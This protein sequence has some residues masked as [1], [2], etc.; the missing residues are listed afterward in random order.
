MDLAE[1][2]EVFRISV[3]SYLQLFVA[4]VI[5]C[6]LGAVVYSPGD[7]NTAAYIYLLFAALFAANAVGDVFKNFV[8]TREGFEL[9]NVCKSHLAFIWAEV[10]RIRPVKIVT[11]YRYGGIP[12]CCKRKTDVAR[13]D[14]VQEIPKDRRPQK[15]TKLDRANT[16][17]CTIQ[18]F[19]LGG[20]TLEDFCARLNALRTGGGGVAAVA[21]AT[22]SPEE[23]SSF[24]VSFSEGAVVRNTSDSTA[25]SSQ[26]VGTLPASAVITAIATVTL[27]SGASRVQFEL[28]G[29]EGWVSDKSSDSTRL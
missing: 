2:R 20:M 15:M 14:L 12:L 10:A 1:G 21:V 11:T 25:S 23:W 29:L 5:C 24:T 13:I 8:I 4:A 7:D 26:I 28:E 9:T 17:D 18:G 3:C 19:D 27:A 16:A 6:G 22:D